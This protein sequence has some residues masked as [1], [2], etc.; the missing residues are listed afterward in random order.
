[1]GELHS[2]LICDHFFSSILVEYRK[3]SI[4]FVYLFI[5]K[6]SIRSTCHVV[7]STQIKMKSY[8]YQIRKDHYVRDCGVY[9]CAYVCVS[10]R[11]CVW[12]R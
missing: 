6:I 12:G 3:V 8:L 2:S 9:A 7:I 1:V 11:V 4:E 10:V 5:S